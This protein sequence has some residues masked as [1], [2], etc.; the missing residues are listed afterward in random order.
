MPPHPQ[1]PLPLFFVPIQSPLS[2]FRTNLIPFCDAQVLD[3]SANAIVALAPL[4]VALPALAELI[5]DDNS[6]RALG[7]ELEG[8]PKLKKL[9]A[10]SNRIAAIDPFSGEQVNRSGTR[11]AMFR[12]AFFFKSCL[13]LFLA[14]DVRGAPGMARSLWR[15]VRF[16]A[17]K[18]CLL[19]HSASQVKTVIISSS[20]N[21]PS[22]HFS[23]KSA[24]AGRGVFLLL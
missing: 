15:S 21:L 6:L 17:S 2:K 3:M 7:N 14:R 5:L 11:E 1:K 22:L 19:Q 9:S 18:T 20:L 8:L 23:R 16:S 4:A 10:R 13:L 24:S 12:F